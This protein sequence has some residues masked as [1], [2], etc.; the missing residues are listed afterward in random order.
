MPF[1][2]MYRVVNSYQWQHCFL[3]SG[4]LSTRIQKMG[5]ASNKSGSG[6]RSRF[7]FFFTNNFFKLIFHRCFRNGQRAKELLCYGKHKNRKTQSCSRVNSSSWLISYSRTRLL[8]IFGKLKKF[9]NCKVD[10]LGVQAIFS[11]VGYPGVHI[12]HF[13]LHMY[14]APAFTSIFVFL[15]LLLL[16]STLL[17]E[18]Y[19]G[20]EEMKK[21]KGEKFL[22]FYF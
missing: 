10:V 20:L 6:I 17:L 16:N 12:A 2:N 13:H 22:F 8:K 14:N 18:K 3:L 9:Q 19:P 7:K 4:S 11:F 1:A 5:H 15:L 21:N